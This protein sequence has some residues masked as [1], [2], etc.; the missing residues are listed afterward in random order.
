MFNTYTYIEKPHW[1]QAP[2]IVVTVFSDYEKTFICTVHLA[3]AES[4]RIILDRIVK[5]VGV[6]NI[7]GFLITYNLMFPQLQCHHYYLQKDTTWPSSE[8]Q[9]MAC[10]HSGPAAAFYGHFRKD[11]GPDGSLKLFVNA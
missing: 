3:G 10:E 6:K 2:D 1:Y 11:I 9:P 8:H 5:E 7:T 4:V